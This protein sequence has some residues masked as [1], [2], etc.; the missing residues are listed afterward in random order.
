[1]SADSTSI[2]DFRAARAGR[3]FVTSAPSGTGKT[4]IS[5]R[6]ENAGIVRVS[7]SSTTRP[8]REGEEHG[9][10]YFFVDDKEFQNMRAQGAFLEWA[11]VYGHYYGTEKEWVLRHLAQNENILLEID[12]QGARS[13]KQQMPEATLIFIRPPSLEQLEERIKSRGKDSEDVI[14]RRM[15]AAEEELSHISEYDHVIINDNL[16]RAVE[17]IRTIITQGEPHV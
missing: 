16:E 10:Q 12:V 17:E 9:K 4:T 8:P 14:S 3:L 6:L 5:S 2:N 15:S 1:M 11:E 13:I 7:I